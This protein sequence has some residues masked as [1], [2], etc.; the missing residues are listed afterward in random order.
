[1]ILKLV[2]R[3]TKS[4][5]IG[6]TFRSL[7]QDS[8]EAVDFIECSDANEYYRPPATTMKRMKQSEQKAIEEARGKQSLSRRTKL[9]SILTFK[10][11]TLLI[12]QKKAVLLHRFFATSCGESTSCD[13]ELSNNL[14]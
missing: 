10:K 11:V 2:S 3:N 14:T 9:R 8:Q 1:M 13:G 7:W 5:Y 6:K 4:S 12:F